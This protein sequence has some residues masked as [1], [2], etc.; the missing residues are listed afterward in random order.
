MREAISDLCPKEVP[1]RKEFQ[2]VSGH[3]GP[4]VHDGFEYLTRAS[5]DGRYIVD[6]IDEPQEAPRSAAEGSLFL[7]S[8]IKETLFSTV[9]LQKSWARNGFYK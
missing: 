2:I 3:L 1:M 8:R 4:G 7:R 5:S 9:F 6:D